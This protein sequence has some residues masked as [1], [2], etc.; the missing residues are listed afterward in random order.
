MTLLELYDFVARGG[1]PALMAV[2]L[3]AGSK[4]VWVWGWQFDHE[5]R[6][7]DRFEEIALTNAKIA[8]TT[9]QVIAA[10]RS[11]KDSEH[12]TA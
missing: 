2:I 12:G 4:R 7:A 3:W 5:R 9:T 11:E 8:A 10:A 1:F 6:R